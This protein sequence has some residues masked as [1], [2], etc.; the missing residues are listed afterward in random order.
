MPVALGASTVTPMS[1]T[2]TP[3]PSLTPTATNTKFRYPT[4]VPYLTLGANVTPNLVRQFTSSE[5]TSIAGTRAVFLTNVA[6]RN[7]VPN[8]ATPTPKLPKPTFTRVVGATSQPAV[9][10]VSPVLQVGMR[11]QVSMRQSGSNRVRNEPSTQAS[12]LGTLSPGTTFTVMA[13]PVCNV[14][15]WWQIRTDSGLV[16]W[17]P[18]GDVAE[19]GGDYWLEPLTS[20]G[21]ATDAGGGQK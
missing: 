10:S 15:W 7:R 2:D 18:E 5:A 13:G 1:P 11:T 8:V 12:L 6:Q 9:C 17:T 16:G 4:A 20:G 3:P 21:S 19:R 14:Y